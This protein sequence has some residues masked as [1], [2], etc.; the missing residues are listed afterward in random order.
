MT[1]LVPLSGGCEMRPYL[2]WH[3]D[4]DIVHRYI[5]KPG[6]EPL[7]GTIVYLGP[8]DFR[9]RLDA[10]AATASRLKPFIH[11]TIS[12]PEGFLATRKVWLSIAAAAIKM[13]GLN[14]DRT[15]WFAARHSDQNC[16]HIHCVVS[17]QDFRGRDI[18]VSGNQEKSEAIHK[19]LCRLIGLPEP[20][21]FSPDDGPRLAPVTPVR[22]LIGE[23]KKQL[24]SDLQHVFLSHQPEDLDQMNRQLRLLAGGFQGTIVKTRSG[25][26]SILW[27]NN[28]AEFFTGEIGLGWQPR[29]VFRRFSFARA[30][31][32]LRLE[33]DFQHLT[34]VFRKPEMEELL[35]PE[36]NAYRV[37]G[38][39]ERRENYSRS[40]FADGPERDF[41]APSDRSS[42]PSRRSEGI[43]GRKAS[44]TFEGPDGDIAELSSRAGENDRRV[45]QPDELNQNVNRG[46]AGT[47]TAAGKEDRPDPDH[48]ELTPRLTFGALLARVC[49]AAADRLKGWKVKALRNRTGVAIVFNDH[50]A[51]TVFSDKVKI[52]REGD[53]A[54]LFETEYLATIPERAVMKADYQTLEDDGPEI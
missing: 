31:R 21:Y 24:H 43:A 42:K 53:E 13:L 41:P 47:A 28:T 20:R 25:N 19:H 38:T 1:R 40:A 33:I 49:A 23:Q 27:Q 14:P 46:R 2:E 3:S 51:V 37:G 11:M 8:R 29:F 34:E 48:V 4:P 22:K 44:P 50:S 18:P 54:L 32:F 17:Q 16:D 30:L 26:D 12:L 15:P 10:I 9:A 36:I 52:S 6:A 5:L 39:A 7:G 35:G 45:A